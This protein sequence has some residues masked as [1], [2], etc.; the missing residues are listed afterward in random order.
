[1][2]RLV[3]HFLSVLALFYSGL[4]YSVCRLDERLLIEQCQVGLERTDGAPVPCVGSPM[5]LVVRRV[6]ENIFGCASN[7]AGVP[8]ARPCQ[9]VTL[10]EAQ[11][12]TKEAEC[13]A[14]NSRE[15]CVQAKWNGRFGIVNPDQCAWTD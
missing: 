11:K 3:I 2:F 9:L 15:T 14:R 4:A 6:T 13:R 8:N 5:D 7:R 12:R 1:M 10:N